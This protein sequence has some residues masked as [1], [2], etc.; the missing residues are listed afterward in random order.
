MNVP[1]GY[2]CGVHYA[3][4]THHSK[5]EG[6]GKLRALDPPL[7]PP[8]PPP[9]LHTLDVPSSMRDSHF[10]HRIEEGRK[11]RREDGRNA[12]PMC[13][14]SFDERPVQSEQEQTLF[15]DLRRQD[16]ERNNDE[17]KKE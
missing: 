13:K 17:A 14:S 8:P 5:G 16:I 9:L 1:L 15:K 4:A 6:C 10:G 11:I 3:C 2:T 12:C 7:L